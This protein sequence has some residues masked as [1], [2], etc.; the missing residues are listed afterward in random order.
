M[1][2]PPRYTEVPGESVP[3]SQKPVALSPLNTVMPRSIGV[4]ASVSFESVKNLLSKRPLHRPRRRS[5]DA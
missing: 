2:H 1:H 3:S 4:S 5:P